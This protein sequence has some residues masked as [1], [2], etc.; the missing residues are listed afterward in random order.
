MSVREGTRRKKISVLHM[1]GTWEGK[2]DGCNCPSCKECDAGERTL[3]LTSKSPP[4]VLTKS[5]KGPKPVA[6]KVSIKVKTT[7]V[8]VDNS[9]EECVSLKKGS[10]KK[11]YLPRSGT[12]KNTKHEHPSSKTAENNSGC[13]NVDNSSD[14]DFEDMKK[15]MIQSDVSRIRN[16]SDCNSIEMGKKPVC[17]T[18]V[19]A[20]EMMVESAREVEE[21][22]IAV[23]SEIGEKV[24]C[25]VKADSGS[26]AKTSLIKRNF[27]NFLED[28]PMYKQQCKEEIAFVDSF[29]IKQEPEEYFSD[30]EEVEKTGREKKLLDVVKVESRVS[31]RAR[32][33]TSEMENIY[34]KPRMIFTGRG[35]VRKFEPGMDRAPKSR[36]GRKPTKPIVPVKVKQEPKDVEE[37]DE[38][39]DV[40]ELD[41]LQRALSEAAESISDVGEELLDA[42]HE[43]GED[44]KKSKQKKKT[45]TLFKRVDSDGDKYVECVMCFKMLK[46]SSMKQHYKTHTGEKPHT[47][48]ECE[49]R[50]TRK[51]D[52]ERHKRLVHKNQKPFKCQKCTR[53]FS[54]RK[55]LKAHLQNHDRAIYYACDTC[56]FKFGKREYYENHIRYIHP[57]AD[58]SVPVFPD[59]DDDLATKQLKQLEME[60]QKEKNAKEDS[61]SKDGDVG[62]QDDDDEEEDD[63]EEDKAMEIT[64][65]ENEDQNVI[66]KREL[67]VKKEEAVDYDDDDDLLDDMSI[68]NQEGELEEQYTSEVSVKSNERS[69]NSINL[70][71]TQV[72]TDVRVS[73]GT[74]SF[75]QT[76]PDTDSQDEDLVNKVIAAAVSQA[77]NTIESLQTKAGANMSGNN[78]DAGDDED[79]DDEEI[80]DEA[81]DIHEILGSNYDL[82]PIAQVQKP[83]QPP[84]EIHINASVSGQKRKF[85][86]QIP[87]GSNINVQT[88]E[89]MEM[90]VNMVNQLC[91][92]KELD[93]PIEVI[94][95]N[96]NTRTISL[97]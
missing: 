62:S 64:V 38:D 79:E 34:A 56:G 14:G 91:S 80:L 73:K 8:K 67:M 92:G 28:D 23:K 74:L 55:N 43:F 37:H 12:L 61:S 54:D 90:I 46:E 42:L 41:Q 49:A 93:G 44:P 51:G 4:K 31:K 6:K 22:E 10:P 69:L 71:K 48:D 40:S 70:L 2:I 86:I 60:E 66:V 95:H 68:E 20:K 83:A 72:G 21:K 85:I 76:V 81:D 5:S 89:G 47:C 1:L 57:L 58:G 3:A 29:K 39:E 50:F 52:V 7:K 17:D 77:T 75:T 63:G 24:E 84:S 9:K 33:V 65:T 36:R 15:I 82:L 78:V 13:E 19:H 87:P 25:N 96:P 59:V 30:Q 97:D 26:D 16:T 94:M 53:D 18:T 11:N 35:V 88:P 45:N 32:M 27:K